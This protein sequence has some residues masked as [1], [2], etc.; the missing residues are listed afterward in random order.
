[1]SHVKSHFHASVTL[2][3]HFHSSSTCIPGRPDGRYI[4]DVSVAVDRTVFGCLCDAA[5][6]VYAKGQVTVRE[7]AC[8]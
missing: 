4:L 1:M 3:S 8:V 2:H 7:G 6:A 5:D